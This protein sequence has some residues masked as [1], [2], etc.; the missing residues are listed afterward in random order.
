MVLGEVRF[1]LGICGIFVCFVIIKK[2]LEEGF[3]RELRLG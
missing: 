3:K 2:I 1:C